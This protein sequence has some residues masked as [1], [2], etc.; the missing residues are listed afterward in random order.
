MRVCV[1]VC[2]VHNQKLYMCANGGM[3]VA[4]VTVGLSPKAVLAN[5]YI[6]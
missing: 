6:A 3:Y 1:V 2:G 5:V 4:L